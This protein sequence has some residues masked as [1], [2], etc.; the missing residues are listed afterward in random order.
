MKTKPNKKKRPPSP[1]LL[2]H[3]KRLNLSRRKKGKKPVAAKK[4]KAAKPKARKAPAP[5]PAAPKPATSTSSSG[6]QGVTVTHPAIPPVELPKGDAPGQ[7]VMP[8]VE[9]ACGCGEPGSAPAGVIQQP[10]TVAPPA[11]EELL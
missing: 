9:A 3:L 4:P 10:A 6:G 8:V 7:T 5:K 11:G 2:A 1:K